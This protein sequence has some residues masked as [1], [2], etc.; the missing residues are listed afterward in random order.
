MSI[1][2]IEDNRSVVEQV[3]AHTEISGLAKE[4]N[5]NNT[6]LSELSSLVRDLTPSESEEKV[7]IVERNHQIIIRQRQILSQN[8]AVTVGGDVADE[9]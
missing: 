9:N 6:R 8:G 4:F 5:E 3:I 1:T 7:R 2:F